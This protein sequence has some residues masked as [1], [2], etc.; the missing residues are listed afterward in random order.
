MTKSIAITFFLNGLKYN[1]TDQDKCVEC[2]NVTFLKTFRKRCSRAVEIRNNDNAVI[3][4]TKNKLIV[5]SPLMALD[6]LDFVTKKLKLFIFH[7]GNWQN[8]F[9]RKNTKRIVAYLFFQTRIF[10]KCLVKMLKLVPKSI[11]MTRKYQKMIC[12]V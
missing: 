5:R 8:N 11:L 9:T 12:H 4:R 10:L 1:T 3:S 2:R 6:K 7:K